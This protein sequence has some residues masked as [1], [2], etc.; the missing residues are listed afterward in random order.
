MKKKILSLVCIVV[1]IFTFTSCSDK[2]SSDSAQN[3]FG[4]VNSS[5]MDKANDLTNILNSVPEN[6]ELQKKS[7]DIELEAPERGKAHIKSYAITKGYGENT[8]CIVFYIDYTNTYEKD[9]SY[10][11]LQSYIDVYQDNVLLA[12]IMLSESKDET[13]FIK[14][15]STLEVATAYILRNTTSDVT[16]E[17]KDY[18]TLYG[19]GTISIK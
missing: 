3:P 10:T 2:K 12:P 8:Y 13:T 11:N 15:N 18:D 16:I 9:L 1:L 4:A 14:Q 7:A 6:K 5:V 17:C 19:S